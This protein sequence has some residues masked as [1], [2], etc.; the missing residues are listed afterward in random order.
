MLSITSVIFPL[1]P[2]SAVPMKIGMNSKHDPIALLCR[3][4]AHEISNLLTF[5]L[6]A[7]REAG[8]L[9]G[10]LLGTLRSAPGPVAL[11]E[12]F[13]PDDIE[14]LDRQLGL[15]GARLSHFHR[16]LRL[17]HA[18]L[19]PEQV[20]PVDLYAVLRRLVRA[21]PAQEAPVELEP[22]APASAPPI[23][24][25]DPQ[26]VE[27][28]LGRLVRAARGWA[29]TVKIGVRLGLERSPDG[30]AARVTALLPGDPAAL[31]APE[32]LLAML[33]PSE[34]G[35]I[36]AERGPLGIV[37]GAHLLRLHGGNLF[38]ERGAAGVS[39]CAELPL[40]APPSQ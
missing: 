19:A 7:V 14:R 32:D 24:Q 27:E 18:E 36:R 1:A 15:A 34:S 20:Q 21:G 6:P 31:P 16:D 29:R 22:M 39:L 25:G 26:L 23:I 17:A 12:H 2:G 30:T 28:G 8:A 33:C 4:M 3:G 38:A 37:V 13:G 40:P 11:A 35:A 9:H 5:L 10:E